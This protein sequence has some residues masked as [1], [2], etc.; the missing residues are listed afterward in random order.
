M[1]V[2]TRKQPSKPNTTATRAETAQFLAVDPGVA[3]AVAVRLHGGEICLFDLPVRTV[4]LKTKN[5]SGTPKKRREVDAARLAEILRPYVDASTSC[6]VEALA[7]GFVSTGGKRTTSAATAT[8]QGVNLGRCEGVLAALTG[9]R[10]LRVTPQRWR[11]AHGLRASTPAERKR[12]AAELAQR[13]NPDLPVILPPGPRAREP[14]I[15]DGRADALL[16]L[17]W[18]AEQP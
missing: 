2:K 4:T 5:P 1:A 14:K 17:D 9:R 12:Q 7:S 13:L 16:M 8:R 11:A 6:V 18:L 3:G 10:P 15:M